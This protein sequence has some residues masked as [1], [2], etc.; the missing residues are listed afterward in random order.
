MVTDLNF[1]VKQSNKLINQ[2]EKDEEYRDKSQKG[3]FLRVTPANSKV[4]R[5]KA[6]NRHQKKT[7]QMVLGRYPT[8]VTE[9]GII[10]SM[11]FS[12]WED[13]RGTQ[14]VN[15]FKKLVDCVL[16]EA[17]NLNLYCSRKV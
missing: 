4:S 14:E 16:R 2:S 15:M 11:P 9:D 10:Q 5:L 3:L 12:I 6:W 17:N 1:T 13:F 7:I 8:R